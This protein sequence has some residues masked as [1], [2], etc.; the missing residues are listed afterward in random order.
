IVL[1]SGAS[2][3]DTILEGVMRT[4]LGFFGDAELR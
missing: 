4:L 1:T 3:P 2:C